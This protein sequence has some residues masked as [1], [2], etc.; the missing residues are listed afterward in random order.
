MNQQ[1]IEKGGN[2]PE[3][4]EVGKETSQEQT[5]VIS[6]LEADTAKKIKK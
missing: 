1:M 3:R 4:A 5:K 6:I 2:C